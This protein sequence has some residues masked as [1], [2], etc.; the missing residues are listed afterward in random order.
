MRINIEDKEYIV[1]GYEITETAE[2]TFRLGHYEP[3]LTYEGFIRI[4]LVITPDIKIFSAPA[5]LDFK[6]KDCMI[7]SFNGVYNPA[8]KQIVEAEL[9]GYWRPNE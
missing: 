8:S 2:P 7:T 3:I 5:R 4:N 6:G 9:R 1:A